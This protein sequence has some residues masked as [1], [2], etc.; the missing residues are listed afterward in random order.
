MAYSLDYRKRVFAVKKK[1]QLTFSETSKRFHVSMNTLFRWQRRLEPKTQR[2][3][4]ATKIDME[5]LRK[6]IQRHPDKFQYERAKE[7]GVTQG[8]IWFALKRMNISY[9][10][11]SVASQG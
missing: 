11:N 10:K 1:E 5:A 7:F 3:K 8:A 4:P 9:K 2:N 6:D